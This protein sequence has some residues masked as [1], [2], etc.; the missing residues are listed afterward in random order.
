MSTLPYEMP[1]LPGGETTAASPLIDAD[2]ERNARPRFAFYGRCSTEDRQ[3]PVTSRKW[4]LHL[5]NLLVAQHGPIVAE[6]FDSGM[7][8]YLPWQ[9]RPAAADLLQAVADDDRG[10]DAIVIGEP[11]RAFYSTQYAMTS[12]LFAQHRVVLWVPEVGGPIDPD[13]EV[14]E[15][16]MS[17]FGGLSKAERIRIQ[18]RVH[19]A[20]RAL[21]HADGRYAGGRPPYGYRLADAGPHPHPARAAEGA[22]LHALEPDPDTARVVVSIFRSYR[23]GEGLGRIANALNA[24]K[25]PWPSAADPARNRHR[26]ALGWRKSAIRAILANPR[27]TG[28]EVWNRTGGYETLFDETDITLGYRKVMRRTKPEAWVT[29]QRKAH[30]QL[31]DP[32][33]FQAVQAEMAERGERARSHVAAKPRTYALAG[34]VTCGL[35]GR[36]MSGT[37]T[38]KRIYYRCRATAPHQTGHPANVYLR[39]NDIP[40]SIDTWLTSTNS[41]E[42]LAHLEPEAA[43]AAYRAAGLKASYDPNTKTICL[44]IRESA[45][46]L[47]LKL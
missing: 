17:L 40:R 33:L 46:P 7:S 31:I 25:I 8:R 13:S 32:E 35:C 30:P 16:I 20:M 23:G 12:P 21:V 37:W 2:A 6:Y 26:H 3:D 36:L 18:K 14:H 9:R 15:L 28:V 22:R 44:T 38:N 42:H 5:A 45:T 34:L 11:H 19:A 43:N 4:Q 39:E 10:F 41:S 24:A 1:A 47:T 29:S 27:Y